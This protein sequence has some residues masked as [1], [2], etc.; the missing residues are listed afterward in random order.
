MR[1][2]I[3]RYLSLGLLLAAQL[4]FVPQ[5]SRA[6][7]AGLRW[8]Q[9]DKGVASY[10]YR[11]GAMLIQ[12]DKITSISQD[13][14]SLMFDG[15]KW[16][17][18]SDR[19]K[20]PRSDYMGNMFLDSRGIVYAGG[21]RADYTGSNTPY[22]YIFESTNGLNFTPVQ[23]FVDATGGG[24]IWNFT[25]D[26]YGNV[27]AGEYTTHTATTGGHLWRR[28]PD[29]TWTN[30]A[31]WAPPEDHIHNVYYDPYR[32]ALYVAIGDQD[33]G[34]LK[35]PSNKINADGISAADFSFIL[36]TFPDGTPVE[37]TAMTSDASYIYVG[38]DM[39]SPYGPKT[40]AI[41]RITDNNITQTINVV[42]PLA[43]CGLWNWGDVDDAGN[44]IF[45]SGGINEW[46]C[47]DNYVNRI[48]VSGDHGTSWKVVKDFGSSSSSESMIYTG[49][50][51]HYAT[52]WSGLYGGGDGWGGPDMRAAIGRVIP[53]NS[54]FYVDGT[55]G[56]DWTNIGISQSRPVKTLNYL[57]ML[58]I[59]P[60]DTVQFI[61]SNT[62][63]NPLMVGWAGD[64]TG[65]ISVRGDPASTLAG[66]NAANV[67]A[68]SETFELAKGSW[69]FT[70][71]Q[72]GSSS[73][74]ADTTIVHAGSQSAKIVR[75]GTGTVYLQLKNVAATNISEGNTMYLSYWV[76]YPAD[77]TTGSDP[78]MLQIMD[79]SNYE[80]DMYLN[81]EGCKQPARMKSP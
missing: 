59:Q 9:M 18:A 45:N 16:N 20:F 51:S 31:N 6:D 30:V 14:A 43:E 41:A 22:S 55:N 53:S 21:I 35:L 32:D 62:Y 79:N 37:V 7:S 56:V 78:G 57:E 24:K 70:S 1:R 28:R 69:N 81:P 61:G 10:A 52:N 54:T 65:R 33:H 67:A 12:K 71:S 63:T 27:W 5:G 38:L 36:P 76:Y 2:Q 46:S 60:G 64:E 42:Y 19:T 80:L 39:H 34:I 66:G 47:T 29:G 11:A 8:A 75:G 68:V 72:S 15:T 50:A 17:S 3:I 48:V 77:Q 40:R 58:D 44:I 25:E 4:Y 26:K 49:L 73:I 23:A 13:Y 74:T